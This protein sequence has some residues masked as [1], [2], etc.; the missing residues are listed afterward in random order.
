MPS[1]P[2]L[3]AAASRASAPRPRASAKE[4][5]GPGMRQRPQRAGAATGRSALR[6]ERARAGASWALQSCK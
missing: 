4:H 6:P 3:L 5:A 2:A 1:R